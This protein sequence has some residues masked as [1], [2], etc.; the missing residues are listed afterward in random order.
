[1]QPLF[2]EDFQPGLELLTGPRELTQAD[3][4]AFAEVSGDMNPLHLDDAYA[5]SRGYR[6]RIA[7]GVLGL[8]AVTGLI[9]ELG[10]TRG[11]L[12]ALLGIAWSFRHPVQP[13]DVL[14]ARLKVLETR[15]SRG[16]CR[17]IVRLGVSALNQWDQPVQEGTLTLLVR[18]RA[19][20]TD[21]EMA[22]P[23]AVAA[24]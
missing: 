17:G 13:G 7:H 12:L 2:F 9:G 22:S 11:T 21:R 1:M 15:V 16:S 6:G 14:R 24:P 8:A 23:T 20:A 4:M 10:L 18:T 5:R 19:E 3:V